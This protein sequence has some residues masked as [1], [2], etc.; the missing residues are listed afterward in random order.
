[1]E[2]KTAAP[3]MGEEKKENKSS[4]P[5][6]AYG[7]N[8]TK[9]AAAPEKDTDS[10]RKEKMRSVKGSK[11]IKKANTN[12]VINVVA[13]NLFEFSDVQATR[14]CTRA[15][16]PYFGDSQALF[17]FQFAVCIALASESQLEFE[18]GPSKSSPPSQSESSA[19][20]PS[21]PGS[22]ALTSR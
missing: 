5:K 12:E 1:M 7:Q 3:K 15:Q 14:R 17:L 13:T 6:K 21:L 8:T 9:N 18:S 22:A 11:K 2:K 4:A 20:P 16:F 19:R 10:K